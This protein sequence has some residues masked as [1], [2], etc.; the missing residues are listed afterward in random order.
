[1]T[2]FGNEQ[3]LVYENGFLYHRWCPD[4]VLFTTSELLKLHRSFGHPSTSALSNILKRARPE[5]MNKSVRNVIEDITKRCKTCSEF[6]SRPKRFRLTVGTDELNFNSVVVVDVMYIHQKPVLHVVDESSHFAA[7]MFLRSMSA[8]DTWDAITRCWSNVYLGP[9]DYLRIDQGSNFVA[10]EF[11]GLVAAEVIELMEAP[12]ESPSTM[13]HVERYHGPLR[14]AFTKLESELPSLSKESNIQM[15][16]YC[17]NNTVGPEGLCPTLCVFGAIP[18]PLRQMPAPSQI[19]RAR[20]ID[21]AMKE[22]QKHHAQRKVSFGLKY[23]G[24]YR[25]EREDLDKLHIGAPVRVFRETSKTWQGPFKFVSKDGDTVVVQLPHGR[26]IFRSHVV[27]TV[28]TGDIRPSQDLIN[29]MLDKKECM[30]MLQDHEHTFEQSRA[31]EVKG[32]LDENVFEIVDRTNIPRGCR[33]YG[34][35]W[36]DSLKPK[37]DGS[38]LEKSRL[39]A[40]NY[41]DFSARNIPT[42]APTISKMGERIALT[43]AV[44]HPEGEAYIRDITQAYVQSKSE[45]EREVYLEPV[46]EMNLPATKVLRAINP[47]YGVPE[48]GL[49]CFITYRDHHE[50]KL[51]LRCCTVD[52]CLLFRRDHYNQVPDIV[53]LQVEDSFGAGSR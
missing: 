41:R 51:K 34:T 49:H 26:Q 6:S 4:S 16:I 13:S 45:L 44:M 25:R 15:A 7:A 53:M 35:R 22:V 52:K 19:H 43:I 24:P 37:E 18:R 21:N 27:K 46:P 20:A 38:V 28:P 40:Q 14:A 9:P 50:E 39:V 1:M 33:I 23:R 29:I 17:V 48:S 36:V 11:R 10:K 32:V 2:F 8:A 12:I 30:Y 5:E 47:L 3:K 42:K 31:R